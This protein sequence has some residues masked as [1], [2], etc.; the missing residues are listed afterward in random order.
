MH[1]RNKI[2][3][4]LIALSFG[5]LLPGLTQPVFNL[6]VDV[7]VLSSFAEINSQV[8][9]QSKSILGTV[10]DLYERDRVLVGTLILIFSVVVP[11]LKGLMLIGGIL[12]KSPIIQL[13]LY[14]LVNAI[15]KW[16]MADVVVVAVFL[17]FLSTA[18]NTSAT[19]ESIN[20][21]GIKLPLE[22]RMLMDSNLGPGFYWFLAYCLLSLATL[23]VIKKPEETFGSKKSK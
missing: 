20:V 23:H 15:G 18:E 17:V 4:G 2:S 21:L 16:S 3:L 22:I 10:S 13:R 8:V 12:H 6:G 7:K 1:I 5:L 14:Q 19:K 9:E 11:F